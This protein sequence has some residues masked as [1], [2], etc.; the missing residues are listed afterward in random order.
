MRTVEFQ[1]K[2]HESEG[3]GAGGIR[4][5]GLAADELSYASASEGFPVVLEPGPDAPCDLAEAVAGDAERIR[6][7]LFGAGAVLLRGF[8]SSGA[9]DF[10]AAVSALGLKPAGD[11]LFGIAKRKRHSGAAFTSTTWSKRAILPP[12][13]EMAYMR[14]RPRWIGF[15]CAAPAE[16]YGETP[17]FDMASAY[18]MLP[19][20]LATRFDGARATYVRRIPVKRGRFGYQRTVRETFGTEDRTEIENICGELDVTPRWIRPDLLEAVTE[21]NAVVPHPASGLPCLNAQFTEP[22]A[23]RY[24]FR[25]FSER[26]SVAERCLQEAV[27]FGAGLFPGSAHQRIL[28]GG[29]PLAKRDLTTVYDCMFQASV[30]FEWRRGDVLLLDNIRTGHG[31]LN[32]VGARQILTC[33]GDAYEI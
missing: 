8:R 10:E 32:V 20:R 22:A 23:F 18:R 26:F 3:Q 21:V 15:Y 31:R 28:V 24:L 2:G 1:S 19:E 7:H 16:R 11:Y 27:L 6:E 29:E 4:E 13:T 14:R 17:C 9:Q 12:H 5:R 25:R 30:I 33:F